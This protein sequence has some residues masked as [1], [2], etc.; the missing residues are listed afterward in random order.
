MTTHAYSLCTM[1]A[2]TCKMQNKFS[3]T[4]LLSYGM[5]GQNSKLLFAYLMSHG[6]LDMMWL[7][8]GGGEEDSRTGNESERYKWNVCTCMHVYTNVYKHTLRVM[9][10]KGSYYVGLKQGHWVA[11]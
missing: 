7:V 4:C 11:S 6:Q 9:G 3:K 8:E 2:Q 1:H 10:N 5:P